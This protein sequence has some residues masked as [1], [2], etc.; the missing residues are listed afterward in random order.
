M[1]GSLRRLHAACIDEKISASLAFVRAS[2]DDARRE[3]AALP[4]GPE[5]SALEA[6][7][8]GCE[9]E[10]A[11]WLEQPPSDVRRRSLVTRAVWLARA[12]S[13]LEDSF[14]FMDDDPTLTA[15]RRIAR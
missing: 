3:L 13:E 9:E 1:P 11:T 15:P 10:W 12:V 7:A 4:R 8:R 6:H 2:L 14:A 5:R